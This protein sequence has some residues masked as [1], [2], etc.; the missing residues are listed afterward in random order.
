MSLRPLVTATAQAAL[1]GALSNVFAQLLA[2]EGRKSVDW[3]PVLQFL[4]FSIISTPPNYL[5][6]EFL[7]S[8]YPAHPRKNKGSLSVYNTMAKFIL[9]Q[10]IGAVVNT[11]LFSLFIHALQ[12]AMATAPRVTSLSAAAAYFLRRG[13]VDL[14]R[15]DAASV[16]AASKRDFWP[17]VRAG[18]KVWPA[19][20]LFNFM[21]VKTVAARNLV[22]ALAGVAWGVYMSTVAAR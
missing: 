1:L 8:T 6:Q 11:L 15:V 3:I 19:V 14:G 21:V 22:G 17:I 12:D 10:T 2:A 13:A 7:E 9:D 4:L 16:V 18:V 20:S 5:W